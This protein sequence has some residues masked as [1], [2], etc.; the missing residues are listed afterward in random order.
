MNFGP[1]SDGFG[2]FSLL[3]QMGSTKL[4]DMSLASI[5]EILPISM[6]QKLE[7]L[8]EVPLRNL[9]LLH[10]ELDVAAQTL[11]AV[12]EDVQGK[13]LDYPLQLL[14]TLQSEVQQALDSPSHSI[15]RINIPQLLNKFADSVKSNAL[16]N[17]RIEFL[18]LC[19]ERPIEFPRFEGSSLSTQHS[20]EHAAAATGYIRFFTGCLLSYVP[21]RPFD[22][23]LKLNIN[24]ARYKKRKAELESKLHALQEVE[25]VFSGSESSLRIQLTQKDLSA[26]GDEPPSAMVARPEVSGLARLQI[27]HNNI[28]S[29]IVLRSPDPKAL[30]QVAQGQLDQHR[31]VEVL[32]ANIAQVIQRLSANFHA[33]DDINQPLIAMLQGLDTGLA[34]ALLAGTQKNASDIAVVDLCEVTPFL[35]T[36]AYCSTDPQL[37]RFHNRSTEQPKTRLHTLELIAVAMSMD[38]SSDMISHSTMFQSFHTFY[39]EWKER[40]NEDQRQH[41]AKSSLYRYRGSEE[42]SDEIDLKDF[43]LLFPDYDR[44]SEEADKKKE[45]KYDPRQQAQRLAQLQREIFQTVEATSARVLRLVR[46]VSRTIAETW[47]N[48]SALSQSPVSAERLLSALVLSLDGTKEQL[49]ARTFQGQIFNFYTN[50]NVTETHKIIRLVKKVQARFNELQE[51]WPEHATLDHVL[52][53]SSELLALRHTEPLAKLWTKVEQLHSYIHEWQIVASKEYTAVSLYDQLTELLVSWRRLEL[54]SWAQLLDMEDQKCQEDADAWWFIAYES[55]IAVPM[56]IIRDTDHSAVHAEQLFKTLSEFLTFTSMGQY[57]HRLDMI[58][59]FLS[60][61]KFFANGA[62]A[63]GA[64][65]N[66]IANFLS[67]FD[68][69]RIS[70]QEYL[71]KG[72]QSLEKEIKEIVLLASWK[73]TNI[74]ALRDSAKRSHHKLFKVV[75]KYRSLLAR[76]SEAVIAKGIP[77]QTEPQGH[78]K[79][80]A[81]PADANAVDM[82]A[83]EVCRQDLISW[84]TKSERFRN[85]AATAGRMQ[86]MCRLPSTS[87]EIT[88]YLDSFGTDLIESMKVLRNETPV[89]ATEKTHGLIKHLKARKR[90]LYADTL[91][92]LRQMGFRSNVSEETLAKQASLATILT[93]SPTLISEQARHGSDTSTYH[94]HTLLNVMPLARGKAENHSEDLSN[95]EISRSLGFLE[96]MLSLLIRQRAMVLDV[97]LS[98][99]D[100]SA[101]IESLQSLW[102][103][104]SYTLKSSDDETTATI[105]NLRNALKWLVAITDAGAVIIEKHGKL[106]GQS[107]SAVLGSL[108]VWKQKLSASLEALDNLPELPLGLASSRHEQA[109]A[110]GKQCLQAFKVDL[111][112]LT[113]DQPSLT[114]V[115]KHIQLW[116][117]IDTATTEKHMNGQKLYDL[118]DL[119]SSVSS[120][121]DAVLVAVQRVER[122]SSHMPESDEQSTWLMRGEEALSGSLKSLQCRQVSHLL[123][124]VVAKVQHLSSQDDKCLM[125]ASALC[126]ISIPIFRQ[127]CNIVESALTRYLRF[128]R[129]LCMLAS[130]LANAFSDISVSGFCT[131]GDDSSVQNGEQEKLE[132]GT[133]LGEGEGAEDI[134]KTIED[135]EDLSELAQEKEEDKSDHDIGNQEDAVNMDQD[136][137][138]GEIAEGSELGDDK[139]L[140]GEEEDHDT[141]EQS[142]NVDDLDPSAVDEKIWDGKA[143]DTQ[144]EKKGSRTKGEKNKD[145]QMSADSGTQQENDNEDEGKDEDADEINEEGAEEGEEIAKEEPEGMDPHTRQGQNLELPE[146]MDLDDLDDPDAASN[147]SDMDGL[148]DVEQGPEKAHEGLSDQ[149]GSDDGDVSIDEDNASLQTQLEELKEE[150]GGMSD[151]EAE[152]SP[153]DTEPSDD[154]EMD[155]T[156]TT[157]HD[158]PDNATVDPANAA[159]SDMRDVGENLDDQQDGEPEPSSQAQGS[160]AT[161]RSVPN[162]DDSEAMAKDGQSGPTQ[163]PSENDQ[164]QDSLHDQSDS[165]QVFKKLGD[166]LEKWHRQNRK[167]QEATEQDSSRQLQPNDVEMADPEFEHLENEDM[168]GDTQALGTAT[169][170]QARALDHEALESQMRHEGEN[171]PPD[172]EVQ[173]GA[174]KPDETNDTMDTT[175]DNSETRQTQSR[176]GA[177]IANNT[178]SRQLDD[179][180]SAAQAHDEEDIMDLDT[181]LSAT[182]LQPSSDF[183]F[184]SSDEA[185]RLWSHY[186][187]LTQT[188]SLAL[189]EQ[190][191]LILSPTL[192]TKMRGDFRTGKRLNIKRIIPYIASDFKRDKIWMRRSIPTKRNY[193]IMLAVDDSKSMGESGSAQLAF[194]TLALVAKS[195]SMLEAGE[196]CIVGFGNDVRVAHEFDK[197]FSSEAGAQIFQHFGFQQT[198]TN[199]RKLIADSIALFRDARQ[200]TFNAGTDLWQLE[201]IISDGVC[202]DHDAIRRLVRQA[203]EERIMIVFVIVDALLKGESI[204]DMSQAVFEPDETGETKLKIKRYLDGFPFPYYLVVGDVK[205]LPGVLAQ[206]LRQWFAEVVESR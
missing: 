27:E 44:P 89:K 164:T 151:A 21:D 67:Y 79:L 3:H 41:E 25:R 85:P 203:Q 62:P 1:R 165:S 114:F 187:N 43:H 197:P 86:S 147:S 48:Q 176:P 31:E 53:T 60:H 100:C 59:C 132:G 34:F 158:R 113:H 115:L 155:D 30:Q 103:P 106:G 178:N 169:N 128:H 182:H 185:R 84:P 51:A 7:G 33:Y 141:D 98:L 186:E 95:S 154:D 61:L 64:V 162:I 38:Q 12:T 92:A 72:R 150:K 138:E 174:D 118:S 175:Q 188:L 75:R 101:K 68:H 37:I 104:D 88:S 193:Q 102:A 91:K 50:T 23:A 90:K 161:E 80:A 10:T 16:R 47:R 190:L 168:E 148:S 14:Q 57:C 18:Q 40:L 58:G 160:K 205:A 199:I 94:F 109:A 136:E 166:A 140:S 157:L 120:T 173:E 4:S 83:L 126:A 32:R 70:I 195:L 184:R 146:E 135:D 77:R 119:E 46:S 66:S 129:S 122:A 93:S 127:F 49:C 82:L 143:E 202:E 145:M 152:E 194:E 105:K 170:E 137:L 35:S 131:P 116:T 153:V 52:K 8:S 144:K 13:A 156:Q 74:N 99:E 65:S 20:E 5:R 159:P 56:S 201:L 142:G 28:L 189:T 117:D 123:A 63:I 163:A 130:Q 172:I 96:S 26:L 6:L 29:N 206:A 87:F 110:E 177:L 125:T 55:I 11:V 19:L 81:E 24:Q 167:I 69:F 124:D 42:S 133:G 200:K 149:Q 9:E 191:R 54:S 36:K 198:K 17:D 112:L 97:E 134:S 71:R 76:P 15:G 39:Q 73:D 107:P 45:R 78:L 204:M 196:I 111:Q 108:S 181:D 192:A 121:V 179:Q 2:T 139:D 22:P 180:R 183:P 171:F